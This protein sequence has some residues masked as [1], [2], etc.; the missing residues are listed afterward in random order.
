MVEL[1]VCCCLAGQHRWDVGNHGDASVSGVSLRD[2][3]MET[4]HEGGGME[5][6]NGGGV[7]VFVLRYLHVGEGAGQG[8]GQGAGT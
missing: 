1:E 2:W 7:R 4:V 8:A 6:L 3:L 5:G